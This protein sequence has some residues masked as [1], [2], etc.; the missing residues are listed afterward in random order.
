MDGLSCDAFY[1]DALPSEDGDLR[2]Y[3]CDWGWC[4]KRGEAAAR[5]RLLVDAFEE[6]LGRRVDDPLMR[7]LVELLDRSLTAERERTGRTATTT[8]AAPESAAA[9]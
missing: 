6:I 4:V 9:A 1:A 2:V 3:R 7:E 5:S 8:I